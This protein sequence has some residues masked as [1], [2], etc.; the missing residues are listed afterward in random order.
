MPQGREEAGGLREQ[1]EVEYYPER[2]PF[3]PFGDP[4]K[5][6]PEQLEMRE[7]LRVLRARARADEWLARNPQIGPQLRRL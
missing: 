6:H 4:L 7:R 3:W 1:I 5:E 2:Q